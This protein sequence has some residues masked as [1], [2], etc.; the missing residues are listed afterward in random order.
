[1]ADQNSTLQL[2]GTA[3][4]GQFKVFMA[5]VTS[6]IFSEGVLCSPPYLFNIKKADR[7]A[8]VTDPSL[9]SH[10]PKWLLATADL[11]ASDG[12]YHIDDITGLFN[13]CV[14]TPAALLALSE[15]RRRAGNQPHH[16]QATLGDLNPL[17]VLHVSLGHVSVDVIKWIVKHNVVNGLKYTWNDIKDLKL[18]LC[19]TC[20]T[21]R[22]RSFPVYPSIS[23]RKF[24]PF[25][26][27]SLD[28]LDFGAD[29]L[30]IDG[31]RYAVLYVD[32][33]TR[34]VMAYGMKIKSELLATFKRLI[35]DYGPSANPRSVEIRI[36]NG[37]T[38]SEQLSTPF[39]NYCLAHNIRH[40]Y[41]SPYKHE[42]CLV[43]RFVQSVK[44]GMRAAMQYNQAPTCFWFHALLYYCHTFNNLP[45]KGRKCSRNEEFT[46]VKSDMSTAVPF[47]A[48][49][50]YNVTAA[51]IKS[52]AFGP[53]A[54]RC[55]MIGY[56]DS[57]GPNDLPQLSSAN[58]DATI[59]YK[60]CYI[61]Y[62][63][64]RSRRRFVR[65][66]CYFPVYPWGPSLLHEDP[67]QRSLQ[68][69][70]T[71]EIDYDPLFGCD[72]SD[73]SIF[74]RR[75]QARTAN[76]PPTPTEAT[77][78]PALPTGFR[79]V[80]QRSRD[81]LTL[82]SNTRANA[83]SRSSTILPS[84]SAPV[85]SLVA[86]T[87]STDLDASTLPPT[88]SVD[89]DLPYKIE[90]HAPTDM[91][92][93]RSEVEAWSHP[94]SDC[95]IRAIKREVYRNASRNSW[96]LV[97]VPKDDD[98]KFKRPIKS[99]FAFRLQQRADGSWKYKARL[100]G[101]GYS[102]VPG[103]DF[104]ETFAP[105]AKFKSLC[106]LLNLA[107]IF[108]WELTGLD[109]ESAFLE[110]DLE[111]IIYM[112]LPIA[113][114][115]T[116]P[117][118]GNP[119]LVRL[120][121]SLYGLKQAGELFYQLMKKT[122]LS[123]GL[124]RSI[125]DICVFTHRDPEIGLTT[126]VLLYVD[127]ILITGND[128]VMTAN[129][130]TAL[131]QAVRN[132]TKDAQVHRYVGLDIVR[133]RINHTLTIS[134][135]PYTRQLLTQLPTGTKSKSNP[136]SPYADYTKRGE[137]KNPPIHV[138]VGQ[139][140]F[141]ADR[142]RPELLAAESILGSGASDPSDAHITGVKHVLKYLQSDPGAGIT[143]GPGSHPD[144]IELFGISD[145]SY[146]TT[147]DSKSQ[148]GYCFYLNTKSG[149]I[150][151]KSKKDSSV[152]HSACDTEIK[153]IDLAVMQSIW[154]R[155]F[156]AE[157]GFPQTTPTV[158]WTDSESAKILCESYNISEKSGHMTMRLNFIHQEIMRGNIILRYLNTDDNVADVLT[159]PLPSDSF[160][161]HAIKLRA[162]F[163]EPLH[164]GISRKAK[165]KQAKKSVRV[166]FKS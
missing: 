163:N 27:I 154:L 108:D 140:R 160:G 134:Q 90:D 157:L 14:H 67:H 49:G 32:R 112:N 15:R 3:R 150:L 36:I 56:A 129:V 84:S 127:D 74:S 31:Y 75:H 137:G 106:I 39:I 8:W 164:S 44:I 66:D 103:R 159:K 5:D 120:L 18:G 148:L 37:D 100:V 68:E 96:K 92:V 153:A 145:A 22:M 98:G 1:M 47:Y 48:E 88:G 10:D 62:S 87:S 76:D 121:K 73:V 29:N 19:P 45:R 101:C 95:W 30:S 71:E 25:E 158:I 50:Y 132:L 109:V 142:S 118:T 111:D 144:E 33:A 13:Y 97:D 77:A 21:S 43:E 133:D 41:S 58:P 107:A 104:N 141:L 152:S 147:G 117:N 119:W 99:K 12:L 131:E 35:R 113:V 46:G 61:L 115:G 52:K 136:L 110:P 161:P 34:K 42:Q 82:R 151:A 17:E 57:V 23:D 54:Q 139:Q 70:A 63:A 55:R 162:G 26:Y 125:H 60:N 78:V 83:S 40:E 122:L 123:T 72:E 51:E 38:G 85:T 4:F 135:E 114:F 138:E 94:D 7:S 166:S 91:S 69:P 156:L 105:T 155:G 64:D 9:S 102:Q 65:H 59:G 24:A 81:D 146:V 143:Y 6:P 28:I 126:V 53:R 2:H 11:S 128:P 80:Y 130:V 20:M 116:N 86:S 79:R 93:P 16:Y 89:P 165:A 149:V 124:I